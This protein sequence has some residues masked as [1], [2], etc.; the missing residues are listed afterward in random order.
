MYNIRNWAKRLVFILATIICFSMVACAVEGDQ[1]T[2][3]SDEAEETSDESKR[4]DVVYCLTSDIRSLDYTV[5]TDQLTNI[6]YRQ[7]YDVLVQKDNEGNYI[8]ALAESWEPSDDGLVWTY[9]LREDV[10]MHDGTNM[11][12]EDVAWSLNYGINAG[13]GVSSSMTNMVNAEVIDEYTVAVS[14]SAPYAAH[15]EVMQGNGRISK[16][17]ATDFENNPIGTGP[18][19]FVSRSSGDNLIL[20]AWDQYYRGAPAIKDLK[21]KVITDSTTQISAL[22]SGEID[23]LTHA[24]LA[25]SDTVE[26]D[27]NLVWQEM[28]FRGNVWIY[29]NLAKTPFDNILARKAVQYGVDMNAMLLGGSEGRGNLLKSFFPENVAASPE[30][31]YQPPY[32]YDLEKAKDYLEQYKAETGVDEVTIEIWAPTTTM[33][34]FPAK[35]LEGLLREVGFD[36]TLIELDRQTFWASMSSGEFTIMIPGTSWP[37]Q[38]ADGLYL[39]YESNTRIAQGIGMNDPDVDEL[40]NS[41]RA[42]NDEEARREKYADFQKIMDDNAYVI[43]LY[44]PNCAV[45]Y[46]KDLKGVTDN[47]IYQFYVFDWSW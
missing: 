34:L 21:F 30:K 19:K 44:Q 46:T 33:Y 2:T 17:E 13:T 8:P 26:S 35:T 5:T 42:S 20:E 10:V 32:T 6:V 43:T 4:T 18:Y 37:V 28:T 23:F 15:L 36:V 39:Y 14:L 22:Q 3:V 11:T 47:D 40:L 38:D 27:Q 1:E 9:H 24:P 31:D 45:T 41:A 29:M 12:A 16:K 25:A 7:I